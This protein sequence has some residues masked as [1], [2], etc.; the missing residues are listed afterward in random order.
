MV[1]SQ[2][3]S[4]LSGNKYLVAV[5]NVFIMA[6]PISLIATFCNLIAIFAEKFGYDGVSTTFGYV[7]QMTAH[8][9]P[10]LLNVYLAT[11]ISGV[12]RI[13]KAASI[14][15]A[16]AAFFIISQEWNLISSA[17]PLPNNFALALISAY[18]TCA[19]IIRIR[20]YHFFNAEQNNSIVDNSANIIIA[21][22]LA[23]GLVVSVSHLA[24]GL[25]ETYFIQLDIIPQLNPISFTD[26][27]VYELI[28][29]LLW[30]VGINGHNV[31]HMYKTELFDVSVA[32]M[33]DW[34]NFGVSLNIISTNFYDFFTGMGGSGNTICLVLVMLFFAKSKGYRTL[35]KAVLI[36]S[37]FNIN[38]PVLYG[39]PIIFNPVMIIPFLLVPLISF[40]IAYSAIYFGLV[41]AL[42]EIQS[43][44]MP[45]VMSGYLATGGAASGAV[46]QFFIIIVGMMIYYPFF[47]FMDKR[48]LGLD[49]SS[50]FNNRF[51]TTDEIEAKTKLTSFI[52]SMQSNLDAQ[53]EVEKL[54]SDGEFLLYYQPQVDVVTNKIVA[55]EAL[56]RYRTDEGKIKPPTFIRSF[57][58]LGLMPD[59]DFWVFERAV[60]AAETYA[61]NHHYCLSVNVSPDTVLTN[62]FV[63]SITRIIESSK[64]DFHQIEIEITEELLVQDE[65]RTSKIIGKLQGLGISIALDDFGAGYSSLAYLSR[66]DFDKIKI[67]RSL[68]LNLDSDRGKELFGVVVQLGRITKAQIV[69]E[70]I[71]TKAEL[72]FVS[73]LG[74]RY[75]QGFYFYQPMPLEDVVTQ[76]LITSGKEAALK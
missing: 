57:N 76:G 73:Q 12:K 13:P 48:S 8:M 42:S 72:D 59:L 46:L 53:K 64:L 21:S 61:G 9:F 24:Y 1:L 11:Y 68:V 56:L 4:K 58:Q 3:L 67:D 26:G 33:A 63:N 52:P 44:I 51:F 60:K 70:G 5:C 31:L 16:L 71:E 39:V 75:V 36:L 18:V 14:A 19:I 45:P 7:G 43:W 47:K 54:Q 37:I 41:P 55:L 35:A 23:L 49:L 29:G 28:R 15:S 10:I 34:Q 2:L 50:T 74:V 22:A 69:V 30:S 17:I 20:K 27:L 66:F 40:L 38:E 62:G 65:E 25:Y 6:L 32:N